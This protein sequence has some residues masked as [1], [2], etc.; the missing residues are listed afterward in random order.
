MVLGTITSLGELKIKVI[1]VKCKSKNYLYSLKKTF[2][3]WPKSEFN[4][5]P[6]IWKH[7]NLRVHTAA[8]IKNCF[9]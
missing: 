1:Q 3:P 9:N 4:T 7:D 2:I 5:K 8:I 6:L